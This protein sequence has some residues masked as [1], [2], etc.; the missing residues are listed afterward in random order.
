MTY[1]VGINTGAFRTGTFSVASQTFTVYQAPQSGVP[2]IISV[3][4]VVNGASGIGGALIP[5]EFVSIYGDK[6]G[7]AQPV[8]SKFMER[9]LGYTR[10]FFNGI[11]AFLT[12]TSTG[13][14]NALV[15]YGVGE[16]DL[17]EVQIE[18]QAMKSNS[19]VQPVAASSPAIFTQQYGA[20]Q[21]WVVNQDQTFNS[22]KNPAELGS[23]AVFWATGQG[24]VD[25][26]GKD[27]EAIIAPNFPAPKLPV[28]VSMGGVEAE[29][30]FAGLIYTGVLQVNV[31]IPM[32][33]APANDVPL[34][35]TIGT[36]RSRSEVTLAVR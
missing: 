17:V 27:G 34:L 36:V 28:K 6:V 12:Y 18:Y 22:D 30:V 33:V 23:F 10:A 24:L 11:E 32:T 25:P 16:S 9:G 20:G 21:A 15:P 29:V 8:V 19:I 13:Q 2:P 5:G 4:G 7:P 35:L 1:T 31:K 26:A 3:A 14:M